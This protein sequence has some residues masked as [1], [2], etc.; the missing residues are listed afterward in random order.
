MIYSEIKLSS[1]KLFFPFIM[2]TDMGEK[3]RLWIKLA[4]KTKFIL[5]KK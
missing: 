3:T 5:E 2:S 4:I 1:E